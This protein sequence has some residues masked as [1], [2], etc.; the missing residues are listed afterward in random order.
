MENLERFCEEFDSGRTESKDEDEDLEIPKSRSS[1]K[2]SDFQALF[3]RG[4]D[5]SDHFMIG[6]KYTNR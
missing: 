3:G 6:I 2:P 1:G 5:D 4:N